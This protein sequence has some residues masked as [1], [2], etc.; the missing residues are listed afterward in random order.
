M[1]KKSV[2]TIA[3]MFMVSGISQAA[4][5]T[6]KDNIT[7]D[8]KTVEDNI[9]KEDLKEKGKNLVDSIT[10]MGK[11]IFNFT[12]EGVE[13]AFEKYMNDKKMKELENDRKEK[14]I[15]RT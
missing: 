2:I 12:K 10:D 6:T 8:N 15:E 7:K 13:G 11:S 14:G 3:I 1:L 4:D 9:T 5:T